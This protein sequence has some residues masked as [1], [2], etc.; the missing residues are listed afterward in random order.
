MQ[1]G[2]GYGSDKTTVTI[3][4][5]QNEYY[6]LY[7]TLTNFTNADRRAHGGAVVLIGFLAIPK[8]SSESTSWPQIAK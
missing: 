3:A 4:T 1:V 2:I 7:E 6:P 8:G 5:G